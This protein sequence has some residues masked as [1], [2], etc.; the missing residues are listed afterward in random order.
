[1]PS[2]NS[3]EVRG[4]AISLRTTNESDKHRV[5]AKAISHAH[6]PTYSNV[7]VYLL[8][9]KPADTVEQRE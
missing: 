3:G 7:R 8:L 9:A 4:R 5:S 1:M 6:R 2:L